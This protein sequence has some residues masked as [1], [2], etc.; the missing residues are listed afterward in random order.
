VLLSSAIYLFEGLH[1]LGIGHF[2]NWLSNTCKSSVRPLTSAEI[3]LAQ[4]VYGNSIDYTLVQIDQRAHLGPRQ[5]H[6]AYVS[7]NMINTFGSM[8][9]AHFIHEMMHVWQ[10]QHFGIKYIPLALHAQHFGAGYDYGG[11]V[12]LTD[13]LKTGKTVLDFNYEQQA[14]ILSDYF[15]LKQGLPPK[16]AEFDLKLIPSFE[17]LT[18][19]VT[20]KEHKSAL[21]GT[22]P[23]AHTRKL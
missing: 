22:P 20:R 17:Q 11:T 1:F 16:Y 14:E 2:F 8:S 5:F 6:F 18:R 21:S 15:R 3:A 7:L 10:F 19:P 12:A 23:Y 4:S 9:A 13:A